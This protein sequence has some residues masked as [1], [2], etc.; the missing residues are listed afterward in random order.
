L[1]AE[2]AAMQLPPGKSVQLIVKALPREGKARLS[3]YVMIKTSSPRVPMLRL[4]V[5]GNVG[6][7]PPGP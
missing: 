3:G 5:Y 2:L 7:N 4:P 1:N 6:E